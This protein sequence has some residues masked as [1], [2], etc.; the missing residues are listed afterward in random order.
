MTK[1]ERNF[2]DVAQIEN[3][4]YDKSFGSEILIL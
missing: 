3:L 1:L 2:S 4:R